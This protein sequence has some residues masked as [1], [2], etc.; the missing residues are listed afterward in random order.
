[1]QVNKS[2]LKKC[3]AAICCI[4]LTLACVFG[5][6]A[7]GGDTTVKDV[8]AE[9]N[10]ITVELTDGTKHTY[11]LD[12]V[13]KTEEKDGVIK[14]IYAD[15][16]TEEL[17]TNGVT[18][19]KT[20]I[21]DGKTYIVLTMADK[22]TKEV[23]LEKVVQSVKKSGNGAIEVTYTDGSK[24]TLSY[25]ES[26]EHEFG[27]AA[28]VKPASCQEEGLS[29]KVCKTCGYV[30]SVAVAKD[31]SVHGTWVFDATVKHG[32]VTKTIGDDGM[33]TFERADEGKTHYVLRTNYTFESITTLEDKSKACYQ[34]TCADCGKIF[35]QG[36][37]P[38]DQWISKPLSDSS[39]NV[40]ENEYPAVKTCPDCLAVFLYKD[41]SFGPIEKD[42]VMN[43]LD[44][45]TAPAQGHDYVVTGDP[46]KL[47]NGNYRITL[48]CS[49]CGK[50]ITPE[51]TKTGEKFATC[52]E[53]GYKTF[54]YVYE[55]YVDGEKTQIKAELQLEK[56]DKTLD[57][58]VFYRNDE[59][60]TPVQYKAFSVATNGPEYPYTDELK[61]YV[62]DNTSDSHDASACDKLIH[63]SEGK[64]A[65]CS[66]H[67]AAV[68]KCEVCGQ[69]IV[70]SLSGEHTYGEEVVVP[71]TCTTDGY[72]YKDCAEDTTADKTHRW[73]YNEV[74]AKGHAFKYI[75][76]SFDAVAMTARFKCT[77]SGCTE[78]VTKTVIEK[79]NHPATDCKSKSYKTYEAT[80]DN[81]I[82]GTQKVTF[83][84]YAADEV[85][86]HTVRADLIKFAAID[87][88]DV[89]RFEYNFYDALKDIICDNTS[90][91]HD[92]SACSKLIHWSEGKPANC[93]DHMAAVFKCTVCNQQIVISL[94]GEHMSLD[95][96]DKQIVEATCTEHGSVSVKCTDCG[97]YVLQ[98][99]TDAKGHRF[100]PDATEWA[101]FVANP[102]NNA[103][104]KFNCADCE[105]TITLKAKKTAL[106]ARTDNCGTTQID[107]YD[108]VD[109]TTGKNYT[110]TVE[111]KETTETELVTITKTFEYS[112]SKTN[113][114][115]EHLIGTFNGNPV[116][117]TAFSLA[118]P[119]ENKVEWSE[120]IGYFFSEEVSKLHWNEGK[121]GTCS[122]YALAVFT[123]ETC[124][125]QIVIRVSGEHV[126]TETKT[127]AA[128]VVEAGT[129]KVERGDNRVAN[130][131][132]ATAT[133]T[134]GTRTWTYCSE[135]GAWIEEVSEAKAEL[136]HDI[137]TD[138]WTVEGPFF[139]EHVIVN[140]KV[141]LNESNLQVGYAEGACTRCGDTYRVDFKK[142][143]NRKTGW[144]IETETMPNCAK[145]GSVKIGYYYEINKKSVK[146]AEKTIEMAKVEEHITTFA[147]ATKYVKGYDKANDKF[148]I[149]YY[150]AGCDQFVVYAKGTEAEINNIIKT[151]L[152]ISKVNWVR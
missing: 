119:E 127:I 7:C 36:H 140:G 21:K 93:S 91:S 118:A 110:Y 87:L 42:G 71:A 56:T 100:A 6:A 143:G 107:K 48:I 29:I 148:F 54:T 63:W 98:S 142:T 130:A 40:C 108:F 69:Y 137:P 9:N 62:C 17:N 122:D 139:A 23:A 144:Q 2:L 90:D 106:P 12:G 81:G 64:P 138:G 72:S 8:K 43:E 24:E 45:T 11:D 135:C 68:F 26:C 18:D 84:V 73:I 41:G 50:T 75:D 89:R 126:L 13:V 146:V 120:A 103:T 83:D 65:N 97:E 25:D 104:V 49:K 46:V 147:G 134:M 128:N 141:Q 74:A 53:G 44:I 131:T 78:V 59:H 39:V 80:L 86:Y 92:A 55:N 33:V 10:K 94:S 51:A 14:V 34:A 85:L 114:R 20:T 109:V 4:C 82:G 30:E 15:G 60:K 70:I 96:N 123:C 129:H 88:N 16:H 121:P 116:R 115:S 145:S 3:L 58:T 35:E 61:G 77:N 133:C 76:G 99:A 28:V 101:A 117:A 111:A 67:M 32:E 37:R 112:W 57:H 113:S 22:T 151:E 149:A 124:K 27:S 102:A 47:D 19:V 79:S 31:D 52:K 66:T 105:E 152:D 132:R 136:G 125:E 1:M 95:Q 38:V 5:V 150:C